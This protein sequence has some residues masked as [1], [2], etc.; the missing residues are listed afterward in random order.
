ME[1]DNLGEEERFGVVM[2][3]VPSAQESGWLDSGSLEV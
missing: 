3:S 1:V 2:H